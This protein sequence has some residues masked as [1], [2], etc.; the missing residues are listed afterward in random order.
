MVFLDVAGS[1]NYCSILM[2]TMMSFGDS[3]TLDNYTV[4]IFNLSGL[5]T[6]LNTLFYSLS[7]T[8]T[9]TVQLA[10]HHLYTLNDHM[11]LSF[12]LCTANDNDGCVCLCVSVCT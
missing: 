6:P 8:H 9:Q 3:F 2:S 4:N 12:C 1:R 7:L 5:C 10:K 11:H